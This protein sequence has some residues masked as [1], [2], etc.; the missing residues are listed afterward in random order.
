MPQLEDPQANAVQEEPRVEDW[1][2][3]MAVRWR[4]RRQ[5]PTEELDRRLDFLG[6]DWPQPR[7]GRFAGEQLLVLPQPD[8][9]RLDPVLRARME[10]LLEQR[11]R[12]G[13]LQDAL[14]PPDAGDDSDWVDEPEDPPIYHLAASEEAE[15]VP[16]SNVAI[17]HELAEVE[18]A[19]ETEVNGANH[20]EDG[21]FARNPYPQ[22]MREARNRYFTVADHNRDFARQADLANRAKSTEVIV[23]VPASSS[24][25]TKPRQSPRLN[26]ELDIESPPTEA[27]GPVDGTPSSKA[28]NA[29]LTPSRSHENDPTLLCDGVSTDAAPE[30]ARRAQKRKQNHTGTSSDAIFT[31]GTLPGDPAIVSANAAAELT[32]EPTIGLSA[33]TLADTLAGAPAEPPAEAQAEVL[34]EDLDEEV[35]IGPDFGE[36]NFD[37]EFGEEGGIIVEGDL[38]GILEGTFS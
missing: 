33:D 25:I 10:Q 11:R 9:L 22:T 2:P 17:T 20:H 4:R 35:E 37:D 12:L 26:P 34:V 27:R 16:A 36:A 18:A 23:E 38:E 31:A 28:L 6:E 30:M 1:R 7:R 24:T 32:T 5:D 3:E 13:R 21:V 8:A 29:A 19:E 15:E 14:P